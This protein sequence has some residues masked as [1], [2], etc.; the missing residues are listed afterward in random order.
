MVFLSSIRGAA[1][2]LQQLEWIEIANLLNQ[3]AVSLWDVFWS[4]Q[5]SA[6][7]LVQ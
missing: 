5:A 1:D 6:V 7:V 3:E 4:Q 2:I